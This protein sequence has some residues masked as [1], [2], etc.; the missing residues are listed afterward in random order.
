MK[1]KH[2]TLVPVSLCALFLGAGAGFIGH[3]FAAPHKAAQ[4]VA[5][6]SERYIHKSSLKSQAEQHF[7]FGAA[8][9]T[10]RRIIAGRP[11]NCWVWT[12]GD[13]VDTVYGVEFCEPYSGTRK[14]PIK[15]P[16]SDD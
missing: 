15:R 14:P 4:S 7:D 12:A 3:A 9:G 2:L 8:D 10:Y 16:V 6:T 11:A 5:A 13:S 1:Q